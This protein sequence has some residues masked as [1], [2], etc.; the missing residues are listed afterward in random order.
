MGAV[1][2]LLWLIIVQGWLPTPGMSQMTKPMWYP[3]VPEQWGT[4]HPAMFTLM[5]GVMMNAMMFP[6]MT[7]YVREY[8]NQT[9]GSL[10]SRTLYIVGFL[11]PYSLV[12]TSTAIVPL[13]VASIIDISALI[14][15]HGS[16][17]VGG[18]AVTAGIY[19]LSGIKRESLMNCCVRCTVSNDVHSSIFLKSVRN[20]IKHGRSCIRCTWMIF[21][22]LVIVGSMNQ[23]W[24]LL[25]TMVVTIERM[26]DWR[27][28][29]ATA[30]GVLGV[31]GGLV[32]LVF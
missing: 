26:N 5:W 21:T 24:M 16:L 10:V 29:I 31:I 4:S 17:V 18:V 3:G 12:W 28:E 6:A 30:I 1:D 27:L 32:L 19:Q 15:T 2:V 25:L 8:Y 11:V 14:S 23:F 7:P 13:T 22:F 9:E 20:G